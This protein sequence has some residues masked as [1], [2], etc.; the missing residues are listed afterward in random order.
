LVEQ[1]AFQRAEVAERA[2][3]S[4]SP[5][6]RQRTDGVIN[7]NKQGAWRASILKSAMI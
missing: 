5:Q 4:H 7:E 6:F 1:V 2:F 3:R